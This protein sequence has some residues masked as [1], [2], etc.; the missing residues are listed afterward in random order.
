MK[1]GLYYEK[2]SKRGKEIKK[3]KK[4][5]LQDGM[6]HL[7]DALDSINNH[8]PDCDSLY[9]YSCSKMSIIT[10]SISLQILINAADTKK[11]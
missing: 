4:V 5:L 1:K 10:Y 9:Q 2:K 3:K 8:I 7:T 6:Q 11:F